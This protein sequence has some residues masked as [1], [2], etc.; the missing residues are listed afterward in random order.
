MPAATQ[1]RDTHKRLGNQLTLAMA[2]ATRIWG[3]T[4]VCVNASGLAVPG[5]TS[6][7]LKAVGQAEATADNLTGIASAL[8]VNVERDGWYRFGNSSAGDQIVQ[9]DVGA[10]CF[11]VDDQTV[12]KTNGTSTRSVAGVVRDVD[13]QGVWISFK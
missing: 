8:G 3:G 1:A 5:I 10:D 6:T 12:A 9:A 13:T 4:I 11:I 2:A 7:T